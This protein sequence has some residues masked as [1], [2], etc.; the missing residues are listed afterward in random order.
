VPGRPIRSLIAEDRSTERR[1][2]PDGTGI[3]VVLGLCGT[4]TTVVR[5]DG[6]LADPSD[7]LDGADHS[8]LLDD[9]DA[10]DRRVKAAVPRIA[11][12]KPHYA[13]GSPAT[14]ARAPGPAR[15]TPTRSCGA[16]S[17]PGHAR[18]GAPGTGGSLRPG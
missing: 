4:G 14:S 3:S 11:S 6:C 5:E 7:L 9:E 18:Y 10:P 8:V 17:S 15:P 12:P 1:P 2:R 13:S 16:S